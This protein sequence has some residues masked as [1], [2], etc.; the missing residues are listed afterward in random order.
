M[1]HNG[2]A[3]IEQFIQQTNQVYG[4]GL[5][6]AA[7]LSIYG[8][9]FDGDLASW[10]IGGVPP[11]NLL[12]PLGFLLGEP[13]GL[14]GSHNKYEADVS[15]T[16]GDLYQTGNNH[17]LQMSQWQGLYALQDGKTEDTSD[18]NL[19]VLTGWR[20][21]RFQQ[22]LNENP[23]FFNGPFSGVLVQPAA[24]TFMYRFMSNKSETYPEGRLSKDVLR[25]F[26]AVSGPEDNP[27]YT[28]G[29]ER[30]PDNWYKRAIGDEYTI[31]F[32]LLDVLAAAE[33]NP[34]FLDIGGNTGTVNSFT[35]LDLANITGG[36]YNG[37]TLAENDNFACFAY[38]LIIQAGPDILQGLDSD[39]QKATAL[40]EQA[41]A[42]GSTGLECPQLQSIDKENL[43]E[44]YNKYPGVTML[45]DDGT[46]SSSATPSL[47]G[48]LG[49]LKGGILR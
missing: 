40:L 7:F 12:A 46:Y 10:S 42:K 21:T 13:T 32:F 6:L 38:Q 36:L 1:P 33:H 16:R 45:Q 49:H 27:V 20:V 41:V 24:Y 28:K 3:T 26:F 44:Q 17:D 18:F 22:S 14:T 43:M 15:P 11:T 23:Y 2:V 19:D 8:A 48:S 5:D 4:M 29:Y 31:P 47:L 9:V 39:L 25:S 37:A 30:I 35:G 34:Q